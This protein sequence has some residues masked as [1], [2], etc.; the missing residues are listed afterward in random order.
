MS[1]NTEYTIDINY[2]IRDYDEQCDYRFEFASKLPKN[3]KL[4]MRLTGS[5]GESSSFNFDSS[6]ETAD[7]EYTF[8]IT[9]RDIGDVRYYLFKS[10]L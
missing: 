4:A 2:D 7:D 10:K 1:K 5:N 9:S 8:D 6:T 3:G